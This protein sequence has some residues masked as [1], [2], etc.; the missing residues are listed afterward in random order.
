LKT[1]PEGARRSTPGVQAKKGVY[2]H[3][4]VAAECIG[5][6]GG[7]SLTQRSSLTHWAVKATR[8][9]SRAGPGERRTDVVG[10]GRDGND[11]HIQKQAFKK[12]VIV[13]I[14]VK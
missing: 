7:Q 9:G 6:R 10:V 5:A 8:A 11:L 14:L 3:P 1:G 13:V 12:A 2:A 4:P